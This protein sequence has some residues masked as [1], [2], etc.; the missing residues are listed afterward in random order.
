MLAY[1]LSL[2]PNIMAIRNG[3]NFELVKLFLIF[4]GGWSLRLQLTYINNEKTH[5]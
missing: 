5:F 3:R 4:F 2:K 1:I